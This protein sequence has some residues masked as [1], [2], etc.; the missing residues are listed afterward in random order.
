MEE[1]GIVS[2]EE[3]K[4]LG[5]KPGSLEAKEHN[6]D[7]IVIS[8]I[9]CD[10]ER[11][12][13]NYKSFEQ[14]EGTAKDQLILVKRVGTRKAIPDPA[15]ARS[16]NGGATAASASPRSWN[17]QEQQQ[18]IAPAPS[19]R[20]RSFL[21]NLGASIAPR[22]PDSR[23]AIGSTAPAVDARSMLSANY[24]PY[25]GKRKLVDLPF[26]SFSYNIRP[27]VSR[28]RRSIDGLHEHILFTVKIEIVLSKYCYEY[29]QLYFY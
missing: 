19:M 23:A 12:K 7:S 1:G 21:T 18:P 6:N 4:E 11:W 13:T 25:P 10:S 15:Q 24:N 28:E 27:Q 3:R 22:L 20:G 9:N 5:R 8:G 2:V 14:Q 26:N 16:H 17:S 29:V